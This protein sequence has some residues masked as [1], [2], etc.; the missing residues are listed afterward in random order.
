MAVLW[1]A[2]ASGWSWGQT[3]GM[4]RR[5]GRRAEAQEL[6]PELSRSLENPLARILALPIGLDYQ[7]GGGAEGNGERFEFGI[8][9]RIPFVINDDWHLLSRTELAYTFQE[10][11]SAPGSQDGLT[12]LT[13]TFFISPD[14]SLAWD[15][16]WGIGP[17]FVLPT[18]S[19][20]L[21]SDK[22]SLGP[23]LGIYRQRDKWLF[24]FIATQLWSVAGSSQAPDVNVTQL[25]P[26]V[27]WTA[28]TGTTLALSSEIV[29]DWE[30]RHWNIPI[31]LTVSQLTM[32]AGRP[33]KFGLGVQHFGLSGEGAPDWGV[34]FKITLPFN[35]PRWRLGA[36]SPVERRSGNRKKRGRY[37]PKFMR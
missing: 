21:G 6:Y 24:G 13:Q 14:R 11:R 15:L 1:L 2:F 16:Y 22:Y 36:P 18:A 35:S 3:S 12:D 26:L 25:Q 17:T 5:Q 20:G 9:P 34:G 8:A 23:T 29:Y 19:D 32:I 4:D 30:R 37:R 7:D 27:S 31:E 33:L 10:D 28:S